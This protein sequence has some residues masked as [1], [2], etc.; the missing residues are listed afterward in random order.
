MEAIDEM[1]EKIAGLIPVI[2]RVAVSPE[3][4]GGEID[5]LV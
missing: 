4:E 5:A 2:R 1:H 3:V